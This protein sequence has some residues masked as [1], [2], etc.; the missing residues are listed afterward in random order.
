M[1]SSET[2]PWS[3]F[4]GHEELV[5]A[6]DAESGM[7]ALIALHS[8][9]LGPALGGVRISAYPASSCP[10]AAARQDALRLSAAMTY[11]NSLAGLDFGGG[12]GVILADPANKTR[13]L[14][15]AYGRMV[16]SLNGRY[17][18]AGD[19]GMDV[20]DMD[21]IGEECPWTTGRS[22]ENGGVG[23]S[24]ILTAV[25]VWQGMR[26]AAQ[27]V[28]GKP[29]LDGLRIGVVGA[30]KVGGRLVGHLLD[31]G[32]VVTVVDPSPTA[33]AALTSRHPQVNIVGTVD[34]LI[35]LDLD[36]L[37]PNA[38]GGFLTRELSTRLRVGLVCGGANNQLA[39][40][41]VSEILADRGVLFAPD[42]MV[43]CGGVI[44]VAEELDG[45]DLARARVRV[46]RVY[47]TTER[48]LERAV[49]EGVTPLRA[50]EAEAEDRIRAA[51][52]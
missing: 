30:G 6:S 50:A 16:R 44:Q 39:T 43:N 41:D 36:V 19:V 37:S 8:T 28:W 14:L 52:T 46:E 32:A 7:R 29:E 22:P 51:S 21:L 1:S 11:K 17:V 10:E 27:H 4:E 49:A 25:G 45:C 3:D 26:A 47:A 9:T 5:I 20:S 31:E 12:K 18:T 38:M 35:S 40:P 13:E 33:I 48:V 2:N 24:G 23:D 15:H 34:E 42:F